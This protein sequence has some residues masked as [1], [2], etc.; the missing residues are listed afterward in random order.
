MR[1]WLVLVAVLALAGCSAPGGTDGDLTNGWALPPKPAPFRPDAGKCYDDVIAIAGLT[2]DPPV[3][4]TDRHVAESYYVGDLTGAAAAA[5][6]ADV[7]PTEHAA[8][9]E[10]VRRAS[11]YTGG[12]FRAAQLT[13][14]PVLPTTK[15][16]AGGAR[17][18]RCDLI[19]VEIGGVSAVSR[20]GSLKGVLATPAGAGLKLTCFN[21]V[22]GRTRVESMTPVPCSAKHHAEYVGR[23]APRNPTLEMFDDDVQTGKGC[24]GVIASYAG[25]PNDGNLRYRTGWIGFSP[26]SD[27]WAAGIRDVRCFLWLGDITLTG[28][29]RG[30]G[31]KRLPIKYA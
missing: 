18:F 19:Q 6:P 4:C 9:L 16:R 3:P 12:D 26:T 25:V 2:S 31:P 30:A 7:T 13:V 29:Y 17:W 5:D 24:D 22:V 21:P 10:C 1:R 23:W 15:A 14:R 8:G 27:E 11:A 20:T 28:S